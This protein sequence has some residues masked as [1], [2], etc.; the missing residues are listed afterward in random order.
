MSELS[1]SKRHAP[2]STSLIFALACLVPATA[3]AADGA[4]EIATAA[5][6]AGMSSEAANLVGVRAHLHHTLNCLEGTSGADF[7]AS[8]ANPCAGM[9]NGAIAD[10]AD[11]A[12]KK[13]L[14]DAAATARET[15][16][17]DDLSKAK[18]GAKKVADALAGIG[19]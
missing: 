2:V 6:H 3:F 14:V 10:T 16:S 13:Q 19:K 1:I 17:V 15:L 5:K 4:K 7:D 12:V 8:A 9:G 11:A 18:A